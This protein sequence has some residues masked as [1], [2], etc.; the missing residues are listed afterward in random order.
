MNITVPDLLTFR[1]E[2]D[3]SKTMSLWHVIIA[4]KT[5][6]HESIV[7]HC[8]SKYTTDSKGKADIKQWPEEYVPME[9]WMSCFRPVGNNSPITTEDNAD[10]R[11]KSIE[12]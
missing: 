11:A 5:F 7:F 3:L 2:T 12:F 8:L 1:L 4:N 9:F 10:L 6:L